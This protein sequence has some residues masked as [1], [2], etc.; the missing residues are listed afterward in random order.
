[1]FSYKYTLIGHPLG[2]SM[3]P[4]IHERLFRLADHNAEYTLT[5]IA[6][7]KLDASVDK[8]KAFR[9]FN[10]TIPYNTV[11]VNGEGQLF[12]TN[13]DCAGFRNSVGDIPAGS[14][15][16]LIGCGGVGRMMATEC[17]LQ[18]AELT[19]VE[20]DLERAQ[21]LA[22]ELE[23][24][25]FIRRWLESRSKEDPALQFHPIRVLGEAPAEDF[26]LLMNAT[27]VGMYPKVDACPVSDEVIAR[28]GRV[29]DVI[30]NP[31]ETQL[32]QKAKALGKEAVGGSAMLVWQAAAAQSYWNNTR[33]DPND[34]WALVGGMEQEVSRLFPPEGSGK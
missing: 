19:I 16:L 24:S 27:P 14:R 1:M 13:T 26:D 21:A 20:R 22:K 15:V 2:H 30:Y 7:E 12:G 8:L 23:A 31:T 3:S 9:G 18:G 4:W 34:V 5:D 25:D 32:I 11:F 6:P 17:I 29:F 28:S 33:F 10:V